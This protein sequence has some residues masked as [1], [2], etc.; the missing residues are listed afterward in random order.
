MTRRASANAASRR[1]KASAKTTRTKT[2]TVKGTRAAGKRRAGGKVVV[3]KSPP[4]ALEW[5]GGVG[6]HVSLTEQTLLPV[7]FKKVPIRDTKAMWDAIYRLAVRGAPAIGIAAAY[8]V[9]L[10]IRDSRARTP[11]TYLAAL[12]KTTKYLAS[13]RPTAVNLFWALERMEAKARDLVEEL[14]SSRARDPWKQKSPW[15]SRSV[16]AG[17]LEEAKAIHVE[18]QELCRAIGRHGAKVL[19]SGWNVLTH[20]HAGALATGGT[21]TALSVVYGAVEAGKAVHVFA[22]E[23]RPLLQGA[24]LTAWELQEAGVDVTLLCDNAAAS[25]MRSGE[26]QCVVTGADRIAANGDVANKIGTYGVAVLAR[27][28]GI[29]FYVAAPSTTFDLSRRS[30]AEIPIEQRAASEVI[31]GFG[32]RTAPEGIPVYNP[33]F[34]VTPAKYIEGLIT[35]VGVLRRPFRKNIA[36]RIAPVLRRRG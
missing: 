34:D 18:D 32:R 20:C 13:S 36:A 26:V 7:R 29:P 8:G 24:R 11:K 19:R 5:V 25:L 31:E 4:S 14:E 16:T 33:A 17:L 28:H 35:E 21:G 9:V 23:T 3:L 2:G 10:G 27:E 22:D 15:S 12:A 6:G 1:A 30:G